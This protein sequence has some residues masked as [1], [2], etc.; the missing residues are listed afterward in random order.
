MNEM[1]KIFQIFVVLSVILTGFSSC[2]KD[3]DNDK[4]DDTVHVTMVSLNKTTATISVNGTEDLIYTVYPPDAINKNVSWSS[5]DVA[6]VA[7]DGSGKIT[8]ISTGTATVTV[9]S[10]DGQLRASCVV[11]VKEQTISVTGLTLNKSTLSIYVG[12]IETLKAVVV[13]ADAANKKTVWTSSDASVVTVDD[14]GVV[15][16]ISAGTATVTVVSEDGEFTATCT[17]TV[18]NSVTGL[19]LNKTI[20]AIYIGDVESLMVTVTPTDAVNKKTLW[21]SSDA[22]IA[23]VDDKGVV[24]GVSAGAATVTVTSEDG[25]FTATCRVTVTNDMGDVTSTGWSAPVI[26]NYEH[27]MTYVAQV[28]FRDILSEDANTEVAAFVDDE[29]RGHAK[30]VYEPELNVYLVHLTIYSNSAGGETV[31]LKAYNPLKKLIYNDCKTFPFQENT[32]LGSDSE[33]LNCLP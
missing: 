10:K 24:T 2:S 14:N 17:V 32:S 6:V 5:N 33:I 1:K 30:L 29:C 3:K 11:T 7:V 13:P 19:T 20:L 18:N 28:T 25:G 8:G 4:D 9:T 27:S 22:S 26:Y 12:D 23:T 16:G 15:T 31:T 21:T